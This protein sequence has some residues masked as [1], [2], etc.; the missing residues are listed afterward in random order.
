LAST[1]GRALPSP[2][3]ER[4]LYLLSME[5]RAGG[6][7]ASL[8]DMC[9]HVEASCGFDARDNAHSGRPAF[10]DWFVAIEDRLLISFQRVRVVRLPMSSTTWYRNVDR[11]I[12]QASKHNDFKK[13]I[14]EMAA[15]IRDSNDSK[16]TVE[17]CLHVRAQLGRRSLPPSDIETSNVSHPDT[18]RASCGI[19]H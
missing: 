11:P 14:G 15:S 10:T 18:G 2:D 16:A 12:C 3:E 13:Q 6:E 8:P 17:P 4:R 9:V 19:A 7:C 5:I 1:S